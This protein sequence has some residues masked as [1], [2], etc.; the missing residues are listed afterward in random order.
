MLNAKN[1]RLMSA[2]MICAFIST[3]TGCVSH[4]ED[5]PECEQPI[6][7]AYGWNDEGPDGS[8]PVDFLSFLELDLQQ[9]SA[10]GDTIIEDTMS[11]SVQRRGDHALWRHVPHCSDTWALPVDVHLTTHETSRFSNAT[12][13]SQAR[14]LTPTLVRISEE[15][16]AGDFPVSDVDTLGLSI[17]IRADNTGEG[18]VVST[19]TVTTSD[20]V[21][22]EVRTEL[23]WTW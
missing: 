6:Y 19:R 16:S 8:T 22:R 12:I 15:L 10:S 14:A 4:Q 11:F 2:L 9:V 21:S 17:D 18:R 13:S 20:A 5:L 3:L 7:E 23:L 1:S